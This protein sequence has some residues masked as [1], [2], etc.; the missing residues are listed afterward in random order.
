MAARTASGRYGRVVPVNQGG[1]ATA[2]SL[3]S[4]YTTTATDDRQVSVAPP[5]RSSLDTAT[6]VE[7]WEAGKAGKGGKAEEEEDND[8]DEGKK[9]D[10][11]EED[12][13]EDGRDTHC[14]SF[15][16]DRSRVVVVDK[17]ATFQR[18]FLGSEEA[19]R[20]YKKVWKKLQLSLVC[21]VLTF[22]SI[23]ATVVAYT[24]FVRDKRLFLIP[25]IAG[26]GNWYNMLTSRSPRLLRILAMDFG[27]WCV[28]SL[29]PATGSS[30]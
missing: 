17:N 30:L 5:L 3:A 15:E 25:G 14:V 26:V 10:D 13:D 4:V 12:D 16:G 2:S 27:E 20:R 1:L 19:N 28:W 22:M 18:W 21:V 7:A 23:V 8:D 29:M 6:P 9:E 11:E 24:C